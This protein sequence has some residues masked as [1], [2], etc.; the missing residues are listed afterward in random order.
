MGRHLPP[1]RGPPPQNNVVLLPPMSLSLPAALSDL[2][3][4]SPSKLPYIRLAV[5]VIS[6]S[7]LAL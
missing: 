4:R 3:M 6:G 5:P 2:R 1:K 7:P